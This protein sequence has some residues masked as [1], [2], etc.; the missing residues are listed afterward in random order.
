MD[1]EYAWVSFFVYL[2]FCFRLLIPLNLNLNFE[3]YGWFLISGSSIISSY[4]S[5]QSVIIILSS[6]FMDFP[7]L[8]PTFSIISFSLPRLKFRSLSE[9]LLYFFNSF[10]FLLF[11]YPTVSVFMTYIF[12]R[13]LTFTKCIKARNQKDSY[14]ISLIWNKGYARNIN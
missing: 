4:L 8:V 12:R 14:L 3:K 1:K 13:S 5:N 9:R 11:Q 7:S 6:S 2:K 10:S